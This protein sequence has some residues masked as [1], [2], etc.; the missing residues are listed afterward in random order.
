MKKANEA[1]YEMIDRNLKVVAIARRTLILIENESEEV[2]DRF[3][4]EIGQREIE[5][6]CNMNEI[7]IMTEM[8]MDAIKTKN[9][10]NE[11]TE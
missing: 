7:E 1:L 2:V 5:R 6:T 10:K 3:I 11:V 4:S 9:R 8:L